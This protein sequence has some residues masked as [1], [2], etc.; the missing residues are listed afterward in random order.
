MRRRPL[1]VAAARVP[2]GLRIYVIGDIHGRVDL[3]KDTFA[4]IDADRG[5]LPSKKAL[6]I[7][8]GDDVDRGPCSREVINA[9]IAR[10]KRYPS[11]YL[12]GNHETYLLEFL[13]DPSVLAT[14]RL[15]GGLHT[16]LSYNLTPSIAP[17][18]QE[19]VMLASLFYAALP[20]SHLR[21]LNSL[22][23]SH[24]CGDYFFVHAGV[25][26]GVALTRQSEADLLWI[27]NEF[28]LNE[29][30]Y[31][32]IV[33]HGHTPVVE[34]DVRSNRINI[35]TGAYATGRLTCLALEADQKWFI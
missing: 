21:F 9:V 22:E 20:K 11:V 6:H 16:L 7:F 24:I 31:A 8:L 19:S 10:G 29:Q 26:P 15:Y 14:W 32:K 35:D 5:M 28:L 1:S 33:V 18:V 3:L 34:P 25:R 4:G 13:K 12:K 23:T 27:R 17:D 30:S 2:D